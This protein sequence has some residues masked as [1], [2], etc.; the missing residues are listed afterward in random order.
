MEK[1]LTQRADMLCSRQYNTMK[2]GMISL[3]FENF[4]AYYNQHS[5]YDKRTNL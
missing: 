4:L 2:I 3:Y 1:I 5:F